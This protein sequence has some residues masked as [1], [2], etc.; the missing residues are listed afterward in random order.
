M[1]K[2]AIIFAKPDDI[3]ALAVAAEIQSTFGAQATILDTMKYPG[4]W[5]VSLAVESNTKP[6][7]I[8][9]ADDFVAPSEQIIGLWRRHHRGHR[10]PSEVKDKRGRQFS[11]HEAT[12]AFQG[13]LHV[14]GERV[15][16]SV[17]SEQAA[18]KPNQLVLASRL[19]LRIPKTVVTN[20][21]SEARRF[22]DELDG[23]AIFKTLTGTWWQLT[24]TR[25]FK[26]GYSRHLKSLRFAPIIFQELIEAQLDIRAI[27]IDDAVF[28]FSIRSEVRGTRYDWRLDP[29]PAVTSH[30]LPKDLERDLKKLLLQL[31]LRYGAFDLRLTPMGEYVFLEINPT[32]EYITFE[33]RTGQPISRTLAASL[34]QEA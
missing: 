13:W 8:V 28:A 29:T 17:F 5:C 23:P 19:G 15:I 16:N 1:S 34:L 3:P 9:S 20:D 31:G 7:W 6:E 33:I 27:V 14:L 25:R 4:E 11:A 10:V 26:K 22:L 12:S 30:I 32:G 21:A 2:V 18:L 24:E